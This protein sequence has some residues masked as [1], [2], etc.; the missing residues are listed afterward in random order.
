LTGQV[1]SFTPPAGSSPSSASS[2]D[3]NIP[4]R[5]QNPF[6]QFC[7]EKREEVAQHVLQTDG[8][9]L[10][11]KELTKLL[12]QKW[13]QLTIDEKQVYNEKFE[14]E[15]IQYNIQMA[16]YRNKKDRHSNSDY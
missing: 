7:K 4:K 2:R 5:P 13:N 12:A 16:D 11:K 1:A 6:F 8:V 3:P 9:Q 14:E 10:S 15:R